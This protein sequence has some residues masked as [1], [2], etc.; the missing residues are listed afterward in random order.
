MALHSHLE[1]GGDYSTFVAIKSKEGWFNA[2]AG[3]NI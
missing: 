1:A 3:N 2:T